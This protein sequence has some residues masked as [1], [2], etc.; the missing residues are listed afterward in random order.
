MVVKGML[1]V[2]PTPSVRVQAL[3]LLTMVV[4][5]LLLTL[6]RLLLERLTFWMAG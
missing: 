3:L 2:P 4:E 6:E 1:V 5:R